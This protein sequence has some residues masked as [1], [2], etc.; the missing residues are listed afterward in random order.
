MWTH[1]IWIASEIAIIK[2]DRIVCDTEKQIMNEQTK[3]DSDK[4]VW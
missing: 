1:R 4:Y 3:N 2:A